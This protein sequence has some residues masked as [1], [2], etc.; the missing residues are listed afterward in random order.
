MPETNP[1]IVKVAVDVVLSIVA[2]VDTTFQSV[3]DFNLYRA[4]NDVASFFA[5]DKVAEVWLTFVNDTNGDKY[6]DTTML[7]IAGGTK[8]LLEV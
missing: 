7:S 8:E 6:C 2:F 4:L 3:A 1:D 5:H